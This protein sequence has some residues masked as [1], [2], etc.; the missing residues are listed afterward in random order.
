MNFSE[1]RDGVGGDSWG[2][3]L[4]VVCSAIIDTNDKEIIP[5]ERHKK[6][7]ADQKVGLWLLINLSPYDS[8]WFAGLV[9]WIAY[10]SILLISELNKTNM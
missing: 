5:P 3:K 8:L 10:S 6:L 1:M 9:V 7:H 4:K 2:W